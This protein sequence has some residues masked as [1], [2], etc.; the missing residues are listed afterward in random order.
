M[1]RN[2]KIQDLDFED[3]KKNLIEFLK[4]QDKI[5]D[6]DYTSSSMNIL[7]DVLAY[8]THYMGYHAHMLANE[9]FVDSAYLKTSLNSKA[10][11]LGYLPKSKKAAEAIVK[12]KFDID[13]P[14]GS[15][16]VNPEPMEKRIR[17]E[18][19]STFR[20]VSAYTGAT[21]NFIVLDDIYI[22]NKATK[23]NEYDYISDDIPI[24]EGAF[25]TQKFMV[26][27]SI[28]NQRFIINDVNV[29]TST[30][31]LK[32]WESKES[33]DNNESYEIWKRASDFMEI[34]SN[35]RV[36]FIHLNEKENYEIQFGN[37]VYGKS[38]GHQTYFE[39]SYV[40][41]NGIEGNN[42]KSFTLL[43]GVNLSP[44]IVIT[45]S[46]SQ[47]GLNQEEEEELRFNIPRHYRMQNRAVSVEDYKTII[48]SEFRNINSINVW[49]GEDNV[50]KDYGKVF[51]C[52]KPKYGEYLSNKAK[53][54]I[55][56]KLIKKH[57]A[58]NIEPV[59]VDP[60]YLYVNLDFK[61]TYNPIYTD[62][63][64]GQLTTKFNAIIKT[65]NDDELNV[66]GS[67]Y[68]DSHLNSLLQASDESILTSYTNIVL[69]KRLQVSI[70]AYQNY[71][72]NFMNDLRVGTLY[73]NTFK[74]R[75]LKNKMYD[76][77]NGNI[78]LK[79]YDMYQDK[80][81]NY[82][83]QTFGTIDYSTGKIVLSG[84]IF[85][86]LYDYDRLYIFS[87]P[88][89]PNYYTK[90]NNIVVIGDYNVTLIEDFVNE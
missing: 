12:L 81:L 62:M 46:N 24:Y 3:I 29:D 47:G 45:A 20:E 13:G 40:S 55:L 26:D 35:S 23:P 86:D 54:D 59:I 51:I 22:Y 89:Y 25:L 4:T 30:I 58:V 31:K 16:A 18:R 69:E 77:G 15:A 33:M 52:I 80:W 6:Y 50:P 84:I 78:I 37:D 39:L 71:Y 68:S 9:S 79:Y 27:Q 5:Q 73:S 42:A 53:S 38:P 76:D 83:N 66:F 43:D 82:I 88:E 90:R 64:P 2:L 85:D 28:N 36:F 72:V 87:K 61:I 14:H 44:P 34:N 60:E 48:F 32:L 19:G 7:L 11:L 49:G 10:K 65:Y 74:F 70:G 57:N 56:K 17:I 8:N 75:G 41:T 67:Y 21:R 63:E 1:A